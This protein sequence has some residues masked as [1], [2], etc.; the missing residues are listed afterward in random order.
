MT[1]PPPVDHAQGAATAWTRLIGVL[2]LA[3]AAFLGS[4]GLALVSVVRDHEG[5]AASLLHTAARIHLDPDNRLVHAGLVQLA[6]MTRTR[7]E[8][9]AAGAFFYALLHLV[10][11]TGLVLGRRWAEYF[12]VIV[13][14]SLLPL[15]VYEIARHPD[16]LRVGVFA[17]NL[18][19]LVYLVRQV[20][21]RLAVE[22][23]RASSPPLIAPPSSVA[24]PPATSSD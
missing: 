5:V 15:E 7:L 14:G 12:T 19:I 1:E 22:P 9:L 8:L 13:T 6:G 2:K 10:E 23:A 16:V 4:V 17:A 21:G 20:R 24:V 3:S 11:G 18:A